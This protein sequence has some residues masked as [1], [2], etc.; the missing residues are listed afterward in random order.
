MNTAMKD[1][2]SVVAL[3]KSNLTLILLIGVSGSGKTTFSRRHFGRDEI[4]SLDRFREIISGSEDD[5]SATHDAFEIM[6]GITRQRLKRKLST[7]ID[8][9]N[10]HQEFRRPLLDLAKEC[11]ATAISILME[12]PTD[13]C[14]ERSKT[15][16]DR[17]IDEPLLREQRHQYELTKDLIVSEEFDVVV[18]H[19]SWKDDVACNG[20]LL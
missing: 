4:L 16:Y 14:L 15:R 18:F 8:A 20:D 3:Y 1:I 7:V 2:G 5:M 17:N 11:G 12:T 9:M 10:I 13:I 19:E 6:K